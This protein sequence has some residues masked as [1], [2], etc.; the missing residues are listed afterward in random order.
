M[1]IIE[2][3]SAI[4]WNKSESVELR[5]INHEPVLQSEILCPYSN[6]V[7]VFSFVIFAS[8]NFGKKRYK[9]NDGWVSGPQLPKYIGP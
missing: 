3:Y 5:C 4:Q 2:Y 7:L 8:N 6:K 1:Y 9:I